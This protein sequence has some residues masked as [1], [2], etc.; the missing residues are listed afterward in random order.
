MKLEFEI[1]G[2]DAPGFLRRQRKALEFAEAFS[3]GSVKPAT[4]DALVEFLVDFVTVPQDKDEAKEALWDA[5]EKQFTGLLEAL[6]GQGQV[7]PEVAGGS[8]AG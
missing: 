6:T 2:P 5:T 7:S 8:A 1:P 4:V 3:G